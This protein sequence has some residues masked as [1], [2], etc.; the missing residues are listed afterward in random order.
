M[1][2]KR[3]TKAW[4]YVMK[5]WLI[6]WDRINHSLTWVHGDIK[7]A[8]H[9]VTFVG[10]EQYTKKLPVYTSFPIIDFKEWD[11]LLQMRKEVPQGL[12][13]P[14]QEVSDNFFEQITKDVF[15]FEYSEFNMKVRSVTR[16]L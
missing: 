1:D 6:S 15:P 2:L 12:V 5:Q 9:P 7:Q 10:I 8:I 13:S 16:S 11:T 3:F 14:I 4:G